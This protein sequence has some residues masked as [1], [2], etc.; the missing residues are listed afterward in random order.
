MHLPGNPNTGIRGKEVVHSVRP[1]LWACL[2]GVITLRADRPAFPWP[3]LA[4]IVSTL[5]DQMFAS[6]PPEWTAVPRGPS[7]AVIT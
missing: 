4:V 1:G 2:N 6:Q 5:V 7:A 3:H